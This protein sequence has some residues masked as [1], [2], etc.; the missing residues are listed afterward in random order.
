MLAWAFTGSGEPETISE[1]WLRNAVR[2]WDEY[3]W[4]HARAALRLIGLSDRHAKARI[5]LKW[6]RNERLDLVSAQDVRRRILNQRLDHSE[7]RELLAKLVATGWLREEVTPSHD[8]LGRGRP[9]ERWRVNPALWRDAG[10]A[11]NAQK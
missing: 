10:N 3:F 2:L 5:V 4:P 7:T 1:P 11:E 9:T 8:P 6:L